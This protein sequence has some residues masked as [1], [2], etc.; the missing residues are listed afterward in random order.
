MRN[1]RRKTL[2]QLFR[3]DEWVPKL[4]YNFL[5]ESPTKLALKSVSR[6]PAPPVLPRKQQFKPAQVL[7]GTLIARGMIHP[8]AWPVFNQ[9]IKRAVL[10][11]PMAVKSTSSNDTRLAESRRHYVLDP[12]EWYAHWGHNRHN[13]ESQR[14]A[15]LRLLL[16]IVEFNQWNTKD[17]ITYHKHI[18][19]SKI[20]WIPEPSTRHNVVREVHKL[21]PA[22]YKNLFMV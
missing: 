12:A 20:L 2:Q 3:D 13:P 6:T 7:F 9:T 18:V 5:R 16:G 1:M 21:A 11:P 15:V 10:S 17:H 19:D 4:V 8:D 14:N 22:V